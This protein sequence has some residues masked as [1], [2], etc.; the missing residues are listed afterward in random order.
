MSPPIEIPPYLLE[1]EDED[2]EK[3]LIQS[4]EKIEKR[5]PRRHTLSAIQQNEDEDE[6]DDIKQT[7]NMNTNN[8]ANE[9]TV[10]LSQL[11]LQEPSEGMIQNKEKNKDNDDMHEW[12]T[13]NN[14]ELMVDEAFESAMVQSTTMI[15]KTMAKS[16]DKD[17]LITPNPLIDR[18][19]FADGRLS[20]LSFS[21]IS[22][23]SCTNN[24]MSN[25]STLLIKR[26]LDEMFANTK[27]SEL[28]PINPKKRQKRND[29]N[30]NSSF[31]L[32]DDEWNDEFFA[33]I[34]KQLKNNNS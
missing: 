2:F 21:S 24:T 15:E 23:P 28:I 18:C 29:D 27:E 4:V 26:N 32:D 30:N 16:K 22:N 13:P 19:L 34:D 12:K 1:M 8:D 7:Q 9:N 11:S 5:A 6:D 31:E 17:E 33:K 14:S 20:D 10:I 25:K 3:R